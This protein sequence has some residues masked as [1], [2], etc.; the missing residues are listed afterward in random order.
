MDSTTLTNL[1]I[2]PVK[3]D[4]LSEIFEISAHVGPSISLPHDKKTLEDK[5]LR[6]ITS[7]ALQNNPKER[8][9]FF[10]LE[11]L[12]TNKILGTAA[13]ETSISYLMPFYNFTVVPIIQI[14]RWQNQEADRRDQHRLLCFGNQ[15]QGCS[16]L[17]TLFLSNGLRGKGHGQFLS[18]SR[19]LFIAE[20][21]DF[22]TDIIVANMRGSFDEKEVSPF[23]EAVGSRFFGMDFHEA[24]F[25]YST[26]GIE[27]ISKLHAIFPIYIDLLPQKVQ[28]SI[29]MPH[30]RTKPALHIL[31]KEGFMHRN[32]I[33]IFDAGPV[34]EVRKKWIKAVNESRVATVR[35]TYLS[36][37]VAE[38]DAPFTMI[39]N[40]KM[41]FR[42]MMGRIKL[43]EDGRVDIES[44]LARRLSIS[45]NDQIR[46]YFL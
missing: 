12:E 13:L 45:S 35:N 5:I 11:D 27:F 46:Y 16:E 36:K 34:I 44:E 33:D 9:F 18:R 19:F 29:G 22:F 24:Y 15:Y 7:F 2:R 14:N 1:M 25:L 32:V 31:E 10:V 26:Q 8:L 6:S 3:L 42:V 23:W 41:D 17:G 38:E 30:E 37:T 20:F 43:L 28:D 4:D 39:S 40:K 21:F